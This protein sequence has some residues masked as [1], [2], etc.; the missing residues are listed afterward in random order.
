MGQDFDYRLKYLQGLR[1][2]TPPSTEHL[3][4]LALAVCQAP[5]AATSP[6]QTGKSLALRALQKLKSSSLLAPLVKT[7]P[8]HL[9]RRIKSS[10]LR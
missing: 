6:T 5:P 7:L 8:L 10:L 4:Q 2:P 3:G 1:A 9:Q